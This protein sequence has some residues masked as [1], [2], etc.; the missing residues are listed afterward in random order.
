MVSEQFRAT[1]DPRGMAKEILDRFGEPS[2]QQK[3]GLLM[4]IHLSA[5]ELDRVLRFWRD[6][7]PA[8]RGQALAVLSAQAPADEV[9]RLI[10]NPSAQVRSSATA[11]A[12]M[13][14]QYD[15][16]LDAAVAQ[17]RFPNFSLMLALSQQKFRQGFLRDVSDIQTNLQIWRRG[18]IGL[19][20]P[21][22]FPSPSYRAEGV[23][24]LLNNYD[25][26]VTT[27]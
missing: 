3:I 21:L 15:A 27:H 17:S 13:N 12:I 10:L 14:P 23:L 2:A 22:L 20:L 5:E 4:G 26:K 16:I 1:S 6:G 25:P 18:L 24:F 8:E 11:F 19:R 7:N 9:A